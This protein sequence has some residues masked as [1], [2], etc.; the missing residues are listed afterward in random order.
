MTAPMTIGRL[1]KA[2]GVNVETVRY[3]QRRGLIGEPRKPPGGQRRYSQQVLREIAFIRRAQQLG[4][5]LEEIGSLMKIA[6]SGT[7]REARLI[8]EKRYA[9]VASRVAELERMRREL[10]GLIAACRR[11]GTS[12]PLIDALEGD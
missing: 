4:F 5:T 3:Y 1:A 6:R 8:A 11:K 2:A 7:C 9:V 10:A 12:C